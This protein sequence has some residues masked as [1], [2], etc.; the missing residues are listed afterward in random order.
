M[1][2][3]EAVS[4]VGWL[5]SRLLAPAFGVFIALGHLSAEAQLTPT[6]AATPLPA[7]PAAPALQ[8]APASR[9]TAAQVRQAF[10]QADSDSNGGLSRAEAQR[11]PLMPRSF[12]EADQN[13]DGVL[14][15][16]EY[17]AAFAP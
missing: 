11:L 14:T 6:P 7:A 2:C 16:A 1:R 10:E 9:W 13:K 15:L 3:A 4:T 17:A 8:P 12:E 5:A